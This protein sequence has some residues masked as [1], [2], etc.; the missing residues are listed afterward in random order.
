MWTNDAQITWAAGSAPSWSAERLVRDYFSTPELQKLTQ[1]HLLKAF[2][3]QIVVEAARCCSLG[4]TQSTPTWSGLFFKEKKNPRNNMKTLRLLSGLFLK[5][6]YWK[7]DAAAMI[8][9]LLMFISI[10]F[11]TW[12]LESCSKSR[13]PA[14]GCCILES[15]LQ[16]LFI[17]WKILLFCFFAEERK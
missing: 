9:R 12:K 10:W 14:C 7:H 6:S 1:L 2:N 16:H 15:E 11:P 17:R 3:S 5:T 4:S 8:F 13:R